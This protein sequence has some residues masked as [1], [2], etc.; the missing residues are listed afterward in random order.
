[1]P[2]EDADLVFFVIK[3]RYMLLEEVVAQDY[4][5][6]PSFWQLSHHE[7]ANSMIGVVFRPMVLKNA[8]GVAL[9][10][11]SQGWKLIILLS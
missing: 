9:D 11:E 7:G 1:L 5:V 8:D 6:D 2:V 3:H 4:G 10:L